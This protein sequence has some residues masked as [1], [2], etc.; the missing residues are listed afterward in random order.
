MMGHHQDDNVETTLWRLATGA[1]GVGL[2][3]IPQVARI[4]ECHGLYG[5]SGSGGSV[6]LSRPE[7]EQEQKNQ[8]STGG[9]SICR[10]LL[11]FPKTHILATC[12]EHHIPFV[13]DPTNFDPTLTPRNAIRSLLSSNRLPRALAPPSILSLIKTSRALIRDSVDLSNGVLGCCR[14]LE[15]NLSS[16][17]MVVQ[18]PSSSSAGAGAEAETTAASIPT[19]QIQAMALRRIT[20]LISPFQDNEFPLRSFEKFTDRVFPSPASTP[21]PS[22]AK[23]QSFTLGG[24]MFQPLQQKSNRNNAN[25]DDNTWILSRQPF[26]RH[27]LP[28]INLDI[29]IPSTSTSTSTSNPQNNHHHQQQQQ[30]E[31]TNYTPWTLW[32]DRYWFRCYTSLLPSKGNAPE[33]ESHQCSNNMIPATVI[34]RPLQQSDLHHLRRSLFPRLDHQH[35]PT[36]KT[37]TDQDTI[38][39]R[40][41]EMLS[42]NAPNQSR[43]TIPVLEAVNSEGGGKQ[44][45]ALPTM[46]FRFPSPSGSIPEIKWEWMYKMIDHETVKSMGWKMNDGS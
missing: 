13:N 8:I 44:L 46:D 35:Q 21:S 34:I 4:P 32:D 31:S 23:R 7:P 16:G 18:F 33:T 11:S 3:G 30:Q 39:T 28:T 10:P 25:G 37:K 19:S 27:R 41:M 17:T 15:F 9:I 6:T 1:R 14:L 20:E 12:H 38:W 5:V 43:F 2:A 26:M 40:L 24:V 36:R 42:R 45:L 22:E 29:P